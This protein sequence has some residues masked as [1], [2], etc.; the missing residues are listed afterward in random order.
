MSTVLFLLGHPSKI[1]GKEIYLAVQIAIGTF[2]TI[3]Y[4]FLLFA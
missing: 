3:L 1:C 2:S 4:I